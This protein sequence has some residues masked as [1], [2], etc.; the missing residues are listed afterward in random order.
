V[1][2]VM[3][4][5]DQVIPISFGEGID[6]KT[7]PKA[8]VAGK[9]LRLENAVMTSPKSAA[10]RNGYT[11]IPLAIQGGGTI[12]NPKLIKS[13]KDEL[14]CAASGSIYSYSP[15]QQ[16]WVKRGKYVPVEI[17][18][19]TLSMAVANQHLYTTG[20][21][22]GMIAVYAWDQKL[23][24]TFK[25]VDTASNT[26]LL[27]PTQLSP[28]PPPVSSSNCASSP[29]VVVLSAGVF[30]VFYINSAGNLAFKRVTVSGSSVS[31][32]SETVITGTLTFEDLR[33]PY[34]ATQGLY[35]AQYGVCAKSS[36]GAFV[37]LST[38]AGLKVCSV[39]SLGV[40][41]AQQTASA[42]VNCTAM[43]LNYD[44]TNDRLWIYWAE[45]ISL[46]YAIYNAAL[47]NTLAATTAYST[48][49]GPQGITAISTGATTQTV[50]VC[51]ES[52]AAHVNT[53]HR[54]N[55]LKLTVQSNGTAGLASVILTNAVLHSDIFSVSG[56]QYV[57][58]VNYSN[59]QAS[60]FVMDISD[61]A[62]VARAFQN[63]APDYRPQGLLSAPLMK[64]ASQVLLAVSSSQELLSSASGITAVMG[65]T[66][67]L[68]DFDSSEAFQSLEANGTLILNGSVVSAYDG[69]VVTELG[70]LLYPDNV[71]TSSL[72]T[73]PTPPGGVGTIENGTYQYFVIFRWNDANG[74]IYQSAPCVG[75][76]V[77]VS[78]ATN[79][80]GTVKITIDTL[81]LTKKWGSAN[82]IE[83]RIYRTLKNTTGVAYNIN[84]F[85]LSSSSSAYSNDIGQ[86]VVTVTDHAPD[87]AI[88]GNE[89]LYTS[90]GVL[91]NT[92]PPAAMAMSLHGN[93]V[94][95]IN[96]ENGDV[97]YSKSLTPGAGVNFSD[98]LI[99]QVGTRSGRPI[100]ISSMDEKLVIF[101]SSR[102]YAM[103]GDGANDAGTG[104]T[105]T[106]PQPIPAETGASQ[107]KGVL[108]TPMG[109]ICKTPKG[110][111]LLDRAMNF[112]YFGAD[113]EKYNPQTLTA[114]SLMTD[115]SQIRILTSSGLALVFDLTFGQ[116]ST[117]TNHAGY[118]ADIW[119]GKYTY[120]RTDGK[121]FQES[122]SRL[123]GATPYKLLA[124]TA[125]LALAGIQGFQR[126]RR[127]AMLGDYVNGGSNGHGVQVSAAYDF[128]S[129]FQA[130]VPYSFG[131]ASSAGVFQYREHLPIQK[132]DTISLLIEEVTTGDSLESVS[133]TDMSFEAAVKGGL[134]RLPASRSVG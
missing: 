97:C 42:S 84:V 114:A 101:D 32:S 83:V 80:T 70:F 86:N 78:Q 122:S 92:A 79:G 65:A 96:S 108:S 112:K 35:F 131:N 19:Q 121:I 100:A 45:G 63:S 14:V 62:I 33:N 104:A 127:F 4:L 95:L 126:V 88:T 46:K 106:T 56:A 27:A 20:A 116:W 132:C 58:V 28:A 120:V 9:F 23:I 73:T 26:T 34:D 93:R 1:G 98:L 99:V 130:P 75:S 67:A 125:W 76:S 39:S 124:Q 22:S 31:I 49:T 53:Y 82:D 30:G 103:I 8:V 123:D 102:P 85:S 2:E 36:G 59:T 12:T 25:V 129:T 87:S 64:S 13:Y 52:G 105:F 43:S 134:N 61:S 55:I 60:V 54:R 51:H 48:S 109:V 16:N 57:S 11:E 107:S 118:A 74:N 3:A 40:V 72:P 89:A 68:F 6:T 91:E 113:V 15:T 119:Q 81:S 110:L 117:F 128:N 94:Y 24:P 10:K 115:T 21:I 90:G 18:T 38:A 17:K 47:T 77:S 111:Y 29:K 41:S 5:Q 133:L 69:E 66:L 50:L 7:D 44:P 71:I 37:V